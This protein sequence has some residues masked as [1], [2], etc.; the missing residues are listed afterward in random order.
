MN[1]RHMQSSDL[2]FAAGCA[3]DVGWTSTTRGAFETSLA[4]DPNGC[5]I[6]EVDGRTIGL[7]IATNYGQSGFVGDLIVIEDMRGRGIGH[8]MLEHATNYLRSCGTQS[9]FLDGVPSAISLYERAGFR[10]VCRSLRFAG[11]IRGQSHPCV[12]AIQTKD[13]EAVSEID[14]KAFGADRRFFLERCWSLYPELCKIMDRDGEVLGFIM[15]R[16][17]GDVVSVGPWVVTGDAERPGDL[18]EGLAAEVGDLNLTMGILETNS[19][20]V[21]TVRSLGLP[22]RREPSWRMVLGSSSDLGSSGWSYAIGSPAK[23]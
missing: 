1:I 17:G 20:A 7:C 21:A 15:G 11:R 2:D 9:I 12:R 16:R 23:G 14:R 22:E 3:K 6:A 13:L 19:V 4:Y 5:F 8:R 10:K 18:L